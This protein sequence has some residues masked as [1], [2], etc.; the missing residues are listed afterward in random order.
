MVDLLSDVTVLPIVYNLSVVKH[1][2]LLLEFLR[3]N[4][5]VIARLEI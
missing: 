2:T 4:N 1:T 3:Q 5:F